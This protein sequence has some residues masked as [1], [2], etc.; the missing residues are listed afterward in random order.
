MSETEHNQE[1]DREEGATASVPVLARILA[2]QAVH[3][4]IASRA[5]LDVYL[6]GDTIQ[7][8]VCGRWFRA[9]APHLAVAHGTT[10]TDY[11]KAF[12]IPAGTGLA[13]RS[14]RQALSVKTRQMH[15][16]GSLSTAHLSLARVAGA[17]AGRG[18]RVA[19]ERGEHSARTATIRPGDAR[20]IPPGQTR[21]DGRDAAR[22]RAYQQARRA[23]LAGDP[24][25]MR[26][27]REDH[28]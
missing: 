5:D 20:L 8:L 27:Y 28:S 23:L 18:E 17:T 2:K 12:A 9:L 22:A 6:R 25:Q 13:G 14:T 26:R 24:E 3:G 10:A 7:C 1:G 16:D 11:R 19:W 21:A 15:A 4:R